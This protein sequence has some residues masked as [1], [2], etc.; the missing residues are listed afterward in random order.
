MMKTHFFSQEQRR[1][2]FSRKIKSLQ[3]KSKS[4]CERN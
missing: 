1:S 2:E 3:E 4:K